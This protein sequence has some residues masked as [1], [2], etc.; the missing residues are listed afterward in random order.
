MRIGHVIGK[1]T[2][3]IQEEAF[4]GG[5]WLVVNPVDT[6]DLNTCIDQQPK[7]STQSS[8]VIYD[9]IG[10][11]EGDIIGFVEGAEATA[12][13][14]DPT[15]IDAISLAIFDTLKYVAPAN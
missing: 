4:R 10:A 7:L 13:F 1:V 11:G 2:L 9:N 3:S 12:P 6:A 5:R 15:P 8:L 14:E